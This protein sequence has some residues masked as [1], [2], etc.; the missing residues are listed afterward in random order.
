MTDISEWIRP[1]DKDK[2][3]ATPPD[4]RFLQRLIDR[5]TGAQSASLSI[6]R[7]PV[8]MGSSEGRHLHTFEQLFYVLEGTMQV[9]IDGETGVVEAGSLVVFP[10]ETAHRNWNEGP[11]PTLHVQIASPAP[12]RIG[13]GTRSVE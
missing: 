3:A 11:V 2:L 8:G 13:E 5:S 6:V 1:L 7:T 4:E 10:P 12:K 9:E